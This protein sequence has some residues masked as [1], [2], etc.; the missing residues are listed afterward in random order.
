ML[1]IV[2]ELILLFN[3]VFYNLLLL[4]LLLSVYSLYFCD[5]LIS[6]FFILLFY[7]ILFLSF[8]FNFIIFFNADINFYNIK[9]M[10]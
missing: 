2:L 3:Y 7:I 4:L 5:K 8:Y 9:F 10:I 6:I 1:F